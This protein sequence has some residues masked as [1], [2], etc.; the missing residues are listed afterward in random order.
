M[1]GLRM[2]INLPC[3]HQERFRLLTVPGR[4]AC[5]Y[6]AAELD[7]SSTAGALQLGHRRAPTAGVSL[8]IVARFKT[9]RDARASASRPTGALRSCRPD[10]YEICIGPCRMRVGPRLIN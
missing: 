8:P 1:I 5:P 4:P 2:G 10:R 9:D 6:A 7:R 3:P